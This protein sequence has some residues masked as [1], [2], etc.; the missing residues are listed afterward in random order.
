MTRV[1][2][3]SD[4]RL[5]VALVA[6]AAVTWSTAGYFTHLI[7]VSLFPMLVWRNVF[8]G[9]FMLGFL[10]WTRA[11]GDGARRAARSGASAGPWP[12]STG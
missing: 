11:R 7:H 8:G 4:S 6:G 2:H 3:Q 12:S 5:G 1:A 10:S 9:L